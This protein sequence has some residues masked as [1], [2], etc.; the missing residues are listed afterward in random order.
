MTM[1]VPPL[2]LQA[3]F[4]GLRDQIMPALAAVIESQQ[5]LNG[6]PV[7]E[8]ERLVAAHCGCAYGVG[9]SSGTDA[10]LASLMALGIGRGDEVITTP[11]TFFAA[12]GG[13][14]RVGARPVFADIEPDTF[15]IDPA[16]VASAVTAKTR[17]V[18]PVHLYGQMAEMDA[19]MNIAK[20]HK[21]AVIE[22]TAQAIGAAW[23]GAKACSIGTVGCLSF[24]PTKNL[25]GFGDG[26]MILTQDRNLADTLAILRDHGQS[27]TYY[28]KRIG[29][30]FRMDN[31]NAAAWVVK[32]P[33][34]AAW[35][36]RRRALAA[37]YAA[38]LADCPAVVTPKVRDGNEHVFNYYVIRAARR[39]ELHAF[40]RDNGVGTAIYY[41]L[42][43]HQQECFQELGCKT[44]DFP[45]A[46]KAAAEVLAL[47]MYAELTDQQV[48]YVAETVKRFYA[49]PV[50]A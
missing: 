37:R 19:I 24:Y 25:G 31:I 17:A 41:P 9:V 3:Q 27:P 43:L 44:G 2:N 5:F 34:L 48:D 6:Q 47:P 50:K 10:L 12:A 15:N 35:T 18:I 23:G 13:I 33:H 22:D 21:L 28:Y 39:D 42:C 32:M 40:C 4:A 7:R 45:Q 8:L 38:L 36:R 20:R 1:Q 29:G 14:S 26:G 46:E 16:A 30:N 11:F 49:R